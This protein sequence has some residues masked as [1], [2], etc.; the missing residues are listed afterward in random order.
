MTFGQNNLL[1]HLTPVDEILNLKVKILELQNKGELGFRNFT[2][3]SSI[4]GFGSYIPLQE[5][6]IEQKG[7]LLVYY[8]PINVS[9]S[10]KNDT[11]EIWYTQDMILL[12]ENGDVIQEWKDI[13]NFHYITRTPVMDLFAQNSLNLRGQVPPAKYKFKAV[14]K[15]QF[16][17][18][19][20]TKIVDFEIR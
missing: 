3:C 8:E 12:K 19:S 15:D 17:K 1:G 18:K 7:E 9:A 11:Y 6:V 13:L 5:P 14:L 16:K 20:V 10:I 2:F 4:A